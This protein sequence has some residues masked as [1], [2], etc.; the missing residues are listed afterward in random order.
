MQPGR[1]DVST[2]GGLQII[3]LKVDRQGLQDRV[4]TD[5]ENSLDFFPPEREATFDVVMG[6]G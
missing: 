4:D 6:E 3:V 1:T 5:I 2:Y